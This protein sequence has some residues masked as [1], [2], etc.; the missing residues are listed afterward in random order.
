VLPNAVVASAIEEAPV[1]VER[2]HE[3]GVLPNQRGHRRFWAR[4][5]CLGIATQGLDGKKAR[6]HHI[7]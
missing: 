1:D 5:R 2:Y 3:E 4:R 7:K 6:K